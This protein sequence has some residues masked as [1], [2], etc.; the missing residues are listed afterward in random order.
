MHKSEAQHQLRHELGEKKKTNF[1]KCQK[2]DLSKKEHAKTIECE[3]S[4]GR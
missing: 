2:L 3:I 1:R 4:F